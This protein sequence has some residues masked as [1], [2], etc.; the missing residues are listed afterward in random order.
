MGGP[1]RPRKA[2]ARCAYVDPHTGQCR[3]R[4]KRKGAR[5]CCPEH[6]HHAS[7]KRDASKHVAS[8]S[9]KR[10]H[11]AREKDL[12]RLT[13]QMRTMADAE[14]RVPIAT[15]VQVAMAVADVRYLKGYNAGQGRLARHA[16]TLRLTQSK[17][18]I[19]EFLG[20]RFGKQ[21]ILGDLK[22]EDLAAFSFGSPYGTGSARS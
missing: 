9:L 11:Q 10:Y 21:F 5:Y 16:R 15:A 6:F 13:T 14:G 12:A 20:T 22:P 1:G 3:V 7:R 18:A 2:I 17:A 4:V 8:A 19:T